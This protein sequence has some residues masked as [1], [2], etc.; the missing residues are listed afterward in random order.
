MH[1]VI[2][3]SSDFDRSGRQV[4]EAMGV[5][6]RI[7]ARLSFR[8]SK[9]STQGPGRAHGTSM[10]SCTLAIRFTHAYS[11]WVAH[12]ENPPYISME[13]KFW[14]RFNHKILKLK[15]LGLSA[16]EYCIGSSA[17]LQL[18]RLAGSPFQGA[19]LANKMPGI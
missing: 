6:A 9:C 15:V 3:F 10:I 8:C 4:V 5:E 11:C 19:H 7:P 18:F 2:C 17:L 1:I 12:S 14:M 16:F 13:G